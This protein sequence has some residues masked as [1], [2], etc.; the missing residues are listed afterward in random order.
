MPLVPIDTSKTP[1][2]AGSPIAL[3]GVPNSIVFEPTGA[4]AFIGTNAG[5]AVLDTTANTVTLGAPA[6]LGK[7]LAVSTDGNKAIVSNAANDPAT[8]APIEPVAANQRVW[9]FDRSAN[10]LTTFI[11]PG[12]VAA[13][14]DADGFRAFIFGN[15][16]NLYVFSP[17]L[18]FLTT[19]IGGSTT[20][21]TQLASGPFVY[22]AH[23]SGL[24]A[25]ATCNNTLQAAALPT[26]STNIQL[27]SAPKHIDQIIAVESTGVDVVTASVAQP[28]IPVT[29][30]PANCAP[31]VTYA[32]Q[33]FDFGVGAFTAHQLLVGSDNLHVAVLPAGI[34]KIFTVVPGGTLGVATLAAPGTEALSGGV[35]FDSNT[36]WVGVAGSNTVDRINLQS[37]ID[38]VQIPMT[39]KKVDGS[40]AP[41]NLVALRPK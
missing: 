30:T 8:G 38:E 7:V 35:T 19:A 18:T 17:Q 20:D 4:H 28:A 15:N 39:F 25:V 24:R 41:P 10:T 32:N 2:V 31:P 29:L 12:G 3:P 9:V 26:N 11:A 27:V 6:A 37:N 22:A 23:S 33:F 16:G 5:V 13:A 36:L 40:P 1:P 21:A 14:F 34:N